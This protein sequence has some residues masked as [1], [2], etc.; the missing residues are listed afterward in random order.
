MPISNNALN[1]IL[2]LCQKCGSSPCKCPTSYYERILR[3]KI[4]DRHRPG[5]TLPNS[6]GHVQTP[7]INTLPSENSTQVAEVSGFKAQSESVN[8]SASKSFVPSWEKDDFSEKEEDMSP[9]IEASQETKDRQEEEASKPDLS[10]AI[11]VV[12][13]ALAE[14]VY[15]AVM[16]GHS[17]LASDLLSKTATEIF[18]HLES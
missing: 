6:I 2:G 10:E 17:E 18:D 3:D 8:D 14:E 15:N 11:D 5:G 13:E 1:R 16:A 7:N 4:L 12:R 9:S